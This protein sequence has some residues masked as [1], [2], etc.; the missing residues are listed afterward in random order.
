ML[1]P[2]HSYKYAFH[3]DKV[4]IFKK[5]TAGSLHYSI[6]KNCIDK[7]CIKLNYALHGVKNIMYFFFKKKRKIMKP[8]FM[9]SVFFIDS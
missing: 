6:H 4:Y 2:L 8:I 5:N 7:L 9:K 1:C 3:H